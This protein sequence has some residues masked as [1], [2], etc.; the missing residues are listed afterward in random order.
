MSV[1]PFSQANRI[2]VQR[3]PTVRRGYDPAAV[4][5][6][7]TRVA[8]WLETLR[9]ENF[10]LK[11]ELREARPQLAALTREDEAKM[12]DAYVELATRVADVI[13]SAEEYA[14]RVREEAEEEAKQR[15]AEAT[16]SVVGVRDEAE[17]ARLEASVEAE[18]VRQDA[19][20]ESERV[21]QAAATDAERVR[22]EAALE[23]ERLRQAAA[24][25]ADRVTR[26]GEDALATFKAEAERVFQEW[27]PRRTELVTE[28]HAMRDAM[29]GLAEQ[30]ND[31]LAA[32]LAKPGLAPPF[33]D[34]GVAF[35]TADAK[36]EVTPGG[37][38]IVLPEVTSPW[39]ESNRSGPS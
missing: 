20:V 37:S 17:Q 11:D 23:A 34:E 3:F 26:E 30:L 2:R 18:R 10:R 12:D 36:T 9:D 33:Q 21:R 6:F 22:Q 5:A 32:L 25:E 4:E 13:R 24:L 8:E 31:E 28:M 19:S 1:D 7:R 27:T 38:V 14:Q 39:D 29:Q 35:D 15:I 16:Q